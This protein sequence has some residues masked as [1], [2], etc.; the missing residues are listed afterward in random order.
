[1]AAWHAPEARF[2][3]Q[4]ILQYTELA[5]YSQPHEAEKRRRN[6]LFH[7]HL[8]FAFGTP[9]EAWRTTAAAALV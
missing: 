9:L 8:Q 1:L 6:S 3:S 5:R 2:G 7:K 4:A